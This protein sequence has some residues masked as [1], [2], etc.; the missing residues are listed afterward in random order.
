[1]S[2]RAR[3]VVHWLVVS[4]AAASCMGTAVA[5]TANGVP[6]P[7]ELVTRYLQ[8]DI[9][10]KPGI[11][12]ERVRIGDSF[13]QVARRWGQP[14]SIR[15]TS[16][17]GRSKA[18]IYGAGQDA[19][20]IVSGGKKVNGIEVVGDFNSP[21][22]STEGVRFGMTPQQ[23]TTIYGSTAA[24]ATLTTL[25]YPGRGIKLTFKGGGLRSMYVFAATR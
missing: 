15:G 13:E 9:F 11:G 16:F 20:V 8:Q 22:E 4:L 7:G 14:E 24:D 5:Q 10:L 23:V 3:S 25:T 19:F 6:L 18:W 1:M 2:N 12:F 21:F 17:L